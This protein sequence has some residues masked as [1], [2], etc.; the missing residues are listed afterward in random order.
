MSAEKKPTRNAAVALSY[1]P[2]QNDA[3]MV[4][5]KGK[6]A[7]ADSIIEKAVESHIP[8]QKDPSLVELLGKLKIN[9]TIPE[10]LYKAVAEVFAF[11]YQADKN[12]AGPGREKRY[13]DKDSPNKF[14]K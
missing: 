1:Q 3:P 10:E 14:Q 13:G 9:Q 6:G 5:A 8:I 12:A 2:D 11:I 7:V 4:V